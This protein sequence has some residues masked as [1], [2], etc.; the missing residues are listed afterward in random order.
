MNKLLKLLF[1]FLILVILGVA[2]YSQGLVK[3]YQEYLKAETMFRRAQN[4]DPRAQNRLGQWYLKGEGVPRND[5]EA[6]K[7]FRMAANQKFSKSQYNLGKMY[8]EGQGVPR[9]YVLA[10]LWFNLGS[11]N[12]TGED[13]TATIK[14]LKKLEE[15][16]MDLLVFV[17]TFI[18]KQEKMEDMT[19]QQK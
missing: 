18:S 5:H 3:S 6:I 8:Y 15:I 16:M 13:N 14:H 17:K 19:A 9:D 4:G 10:Y 11:L 12:T 7:W 2:I 1:F